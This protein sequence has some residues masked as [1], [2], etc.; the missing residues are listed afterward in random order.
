MMSAKPSCALALCIIALC[1]CHRSSSTTD[2]RIV[3]A[4]SWSYPEGIGRIIF[5]ADHK[6][7]EGFPPKDKDGRHLPEDQFTF[8]YSGT[9][10]LED[11]VLVTEMDNKPL[12]DMYA[13]D[14]QHKPEFKKAV[15]R[16]KIA[17]I[18][19]EKM[20]FDDGSSIDRV[21]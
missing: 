1:S 11:D 17:K 12:L 21:K 19:R 4:W 6:I 20:I 16:L 15:R 2:K 8:P 13:V 14:T 18:D 9:W 7:K 10:R 5:T 3:G